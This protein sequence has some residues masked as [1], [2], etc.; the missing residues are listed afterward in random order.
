[1]CITTKYSAN[2]SIFSL[3]KSKT[4]LET[5]TYSKGTFVSK[6]YSIEYE[7]RKNFHHYFKLIVMLHGPEKLV[8]SDIFRI[9]NLRRFQL[10]NFPTQIEPSGFHRTQFFDELIPR[11]WPKVRSIFLWFGS[12]FNFRRITKNLYVLSQSIP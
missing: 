9:L 6:D 11:F 10:L 1:M 3:R 2:I 12:V 8:P 7:Q 5:L 4:E